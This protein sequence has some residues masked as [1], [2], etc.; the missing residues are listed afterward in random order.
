MKKHLFLLGLCLFFVSQS[1]SIGCETNSKLECACD[2]S[3]YKKYVTKIQRNREIID[4]AL[5]LSDEQIKVRKKILEQNDT[6]IEEKIFD[7]E[8]ECARLSAMEKA[9]VS[10]IEI[11]KQRKIVQNRQKQI[12]DLLHKENKEFSKYLT[13]EQRAKLYNIEN[14]ARHDYKKS[15][16]KHKD[17]YKTNPQMQ[18]FGNPAE[19]TFSCHG[20][21]N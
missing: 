9:N 5:N 20:C 10:N 21:K 6:C 3:V 12:E 16:K 13:K 1:V 14:L 8:Q 17:Y 7:I 18:K 15:C 11:H 2:T 19:E 4:N